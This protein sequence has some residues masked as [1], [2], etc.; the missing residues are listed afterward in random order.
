MESKFDSMKKLKV[1]ADD[2]IPFLKGVLEPFADVTYLTGSKIGPV[3]VANADALLVRTRTRCDKSLLDCSKVQFVAT[4]TIGTDHFD[5]DYLTKSGRFWTNAPACNADSVLQYVTDVLLEISVRTGRSLKDMTIGIVG[6]GNIGSRIK[7]RAELLGMKVLCSDALKASFCN[8]KCNAPY[9]EESF[10]HVPLETVLK[11]A[12]VVTFHTPLAR[13]GEFAT[14]HLCDEASMQLMKRDAW[15]INASRGEVVDNEA[16]LNAL[17]KKR[18]AGAVL[19]VWENEPN[20]SRELL[21]NVLFATPHIAGYSQDGKSNATTSIVRSL[22]KY[23][24]GEYPDLVAL[25]NFEAE[26]PKVGE[27]TVD[28]SCLA[29]SGSTC[30]EQQL[31]EVFRVSYDIRMDDLALRSKVAEFE[32]LRKEYPIRREPKAHRGFVKCQNAIVVDILRKMEFEIL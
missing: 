27:F 1:I 7:K 17:Q 23:F 13:G 10:V 11:N 26:P 29:D 22:V 6:V 9:A 24:K 8:L 30:L 28:C 5:R 15:L 12:D 18:I 25:E 20:V 31:L 2:A 14:Y 32:K 19:D 21:D 4:A 16:L 3:D